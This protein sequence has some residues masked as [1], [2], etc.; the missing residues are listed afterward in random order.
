MTS[1][2]TTSGQMTSGQM[3]SGQ[4]T[5]GQMTSG[6]MTSAWSS[7][8]MTGEGGVWRRR[9]RRLAK[10]AS[11]RRRG[12]QPRPTGADCS[13]ESASNQFADLQK[14]VDDNE[15]HIKVLDRAVETAKL[16]RVLTS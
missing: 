4:M 13:S 10:E 7:G 6:Q 5:S 11:I 1:G 16:L 8:Q 2:R 12:R 14:Q 15:H 3:T 9:Q